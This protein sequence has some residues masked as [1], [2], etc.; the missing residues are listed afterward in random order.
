MNGRP[1]KELLGKL[2]IVGEELFDSRSGLL[3]GRHDGAS[4]VILAGDPVETELARS[5]GPGEIGHKRPNKGRRDGTFERK[6][7]GE[8]PTVVAVDSIRQPSAGDIEET[9]TVDQS[10]EVHRFGLPS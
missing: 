5:D 9:V 7:L 2:A 4:D 8:D 6:D 10:G 3:D 1:W